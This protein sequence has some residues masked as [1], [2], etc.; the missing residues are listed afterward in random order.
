[1]VTFGYKLMS[2]EHGPAA[3]IRNAR[4]AEAA[5]FAFAAISDHYFPWLSE[6]GHAPFA[7]AVLGGLAEAT[8]TLGL[9]TAVTCPIMRYHPAIVAQAAATLG[10]MTGNRFTLGLGAGERLN[11]HVV[12]AGWPGVAE[13]HER[14]REAVAIIQGLLGEELSTYSGRHFRLDHAK[15]FD[16]PS[17]KPPVILAAG[18]DDAAALAGEACD[19]LIVTEPKKELL[20]AYKKAGGKGPRYA[21]VAVC[22]AN[23]KADAEKTA[24]KYFRWSVA[25]WPVLA[26]LPH[27]EAFAAASEHVPVEA[28]AETV[29][30]GPTVDDYLAAIGKYTKAGCDRIILNQVGPDQDAFF[31]F[32]EAKLGP[33]LRVRKAA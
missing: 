7:W 14:L 13:R 30:C 15:I 33:A 28:V 9:M 8:R 22:Y 20:A 4:K 32:F 21:E 17:K 1:M 27:E 10:V 6:Q 29:A 12:G 18:G 24:H 16:R 26:E 5:G 23:S 31:A 25:G 11:E 19:R 3:L 2:E